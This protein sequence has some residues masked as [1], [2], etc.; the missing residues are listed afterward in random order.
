MFVLYDTVRDFESQREVVETV[1]LSL[2]LP[3]GLD[4]NLAKKLYF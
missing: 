3:Y 4:R 1:K 2:R